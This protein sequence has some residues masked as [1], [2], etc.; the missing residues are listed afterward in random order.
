MI[1]PATPT[2]G[3]PTLRIGAVLLAAG[4]ASRMGHRPKCL[5]E[6]GGQP[7]VRRQ[8]QALLDAGVSPVVVVLGHYRDRVA[9]ALDGLP[10]E[11]RVNPDPEAPQNASLH[12]GL[13][14]LPA[15]LDAVLVSLADLPL[16][17]RPE[18][19]ALIA[20]WRQRPAGTAFVRPWV[21]GQP[22]HPVLLDASVR[23]DLLSGGP[24][25][26]GQQWAATHPAGVHRW[27]T[28]HPAYIT[29]VDRPQDLDAL[30]AQG[31]AL[32]WPDAPAA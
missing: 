20:A 7:I 8:A 17:G 21:D 11:H 25:M 18:I 31:I 32:R 29:D 23:R 15:G 28:D 1:P 24:A 6:H 5:L 9:A 3:Q 13:A 30:A 14:A 26:S 2:P 12:L 22:G 27:V 16:I 10:V 4:S 19:E